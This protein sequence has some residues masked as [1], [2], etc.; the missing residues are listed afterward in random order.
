MLFTPSRL[1]RPRLSYLSVLSYVTTQIIGGV[2]GALV[3]FSVHARTPSPAV[4][5]AFTTLGAFTVETIFTFALVFVVMA[6]FTR[7]EPAS[8]MAAWCVGMVVFVGAVA[9]GDVSGAAFNPAV[10]TGLAVVDGINHGKGLNILWLY[11]VILTVLPLN[12]FINLP[13]LSRPRVFSAVPSPLV[14][15]T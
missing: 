14:V 11:W 10:A 13:F 4:G 8:P 15:S 7:S 6:G 3:G 9:C 2:A 5:A 1:G 12:Q